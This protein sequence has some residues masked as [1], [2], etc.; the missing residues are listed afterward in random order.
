MTHLV[1]IEHFHRKRD[2]KPLCQARCSCG[3][4]GNPASFIHTAQRHKQRHLEPAEAETAMTD[5]QIPGVT[6]GTL[7][8]GFR[9]QCD[10]PDGCTT[11]VTDH[12]T[13]DAHRGVTPPLEDRPSSCPHGCGRSSEDGPCEPCELTAVELEHLRSQLDRIRELCRYPVTGTSRHEV[14]VKDIHA[15]LRTPKPGTLI[16]AAMVA[17][18]AANGAL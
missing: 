3:W 1:R 12:P 5:I 7:P 14:L 4:K 2:G 11:F 10:H 8:T 15:I 17:I 6:P 16:F 13:C 9:F 18:A